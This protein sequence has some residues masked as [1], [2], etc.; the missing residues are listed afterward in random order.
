MKTIVWL[1]VLNSPDHGNQPMAWF[2]H[3]TPCTTEA[4]SLNLLAGK[5]RAQQYSCESYDLRQ[6]WEIYDK[7]RN[8]R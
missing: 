4:T 7:S 8:L 5:H 6:H 2:K 1:L 3:K